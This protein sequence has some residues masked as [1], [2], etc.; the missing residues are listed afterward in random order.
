MEK[1]FKEEELF[2]RELMKE[3]GAE[4]PSADFRKNIM[5]AIEPKRLAA[6]YKPLISGKGWFL[7]ATALVLSGIG[8]FY[9]SAG[10]KI[11]MDFSFL[12][13]VSFPKLRF[14]AVMLYGIGFISLFFV[15]I[16]FLKRLLEKQYQ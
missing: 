15:E 9:V 14:S 3:A 2:L 11:R 6:P 1:Q 8:L 16:P 10:W 12:H 7:F 5:E 4:K 13:T